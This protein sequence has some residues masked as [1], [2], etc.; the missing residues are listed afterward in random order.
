MKLITTKF[1]SGGLYEKHINLFHASAHLHPKKKQIYSQR[2]ASTYNS[3]NTILDASARNYAKFGRE[4][5]CLA[6]QKH[7][8]HLTPTTCCPC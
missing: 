1:K 7:A 8:R 6:R 3:P 4:T 2:C 5:C